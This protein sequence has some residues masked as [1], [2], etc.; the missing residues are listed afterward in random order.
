MEGAGVTTGIE[1]GEAITEEMS[2][3]AAASARISLVVVASLYLIDLLKSAEIG[4]SRPAARE[5]DRPI[6][7]VARGSVTVH[8]LCV[9]R[10]RQSG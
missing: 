1:E 3:E 6:H 9:V 2:E 4:D 8:T 10:L 5:R 7:S